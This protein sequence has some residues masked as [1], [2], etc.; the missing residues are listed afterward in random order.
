VSA[1]R[2]ALDDRA[3]AAPDPRVTPAAAGLAPLADGLDL[4]GVWD[5][6]YSYPRDSRTVPFVAHLS[7]QQ[8]TLSGTTEETGTHGAAQGIKL[9]ATLQG[10][11]D[12]RAVTFLKLYDGRHEGYDSVQYEGRLNADSSEIAGRWRIPGGWSGSFLMIRKAG[13][14]AAAAKATAAKA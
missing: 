13:A 14:K 12:A 8:A 1:R 2:W 9:G 5:G 4:S 10:R 11:R 7:E 3:G 6:V